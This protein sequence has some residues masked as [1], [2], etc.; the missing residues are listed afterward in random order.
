MEREILGMCIG[1]STPISITYISSTDN[2]PVSGEYVSLD[3]SGK[4]V[5]GMVEGTLRGSPAIPED[6]LNLESVSKIMEFEEESEHY[7]KGSIKLLGE[8]VHGTPV[9]PK[10]PP[11]P[12]T[13]ICR[14]DSKVLKE[15][16]SK[17]EIKIGT[18]LSHPEVE[19]HI[20]ANKMLTRHLAVLAITGAGKSNT[21]SVL[22]EGL[23]KL[24]G[25][26]IIFDMHSEYVNAR[27]S[28]K[29]N[30]VVPMLNPLYLSPTE[31]KILVDIGKD[32]HVQERYLRKAYHQAME[33]V[34]QGGSRDFI[35]VLISILEDIQDEEDQRTQSE[36]NALVGVI[37]KVEDFNLKYKGLV[38]SGAGDILD[39]FIQGQANVIDLGQVD[40][41]YSD[42]IVSHVLRKLLNKRKNREIPPAFCILEEAHILAPA[43]RPTLSKYWIDRISREG[44]KFGVGL[45]MV[46]QRPKSLDANSL[47]Q[48]NNSIIMRLIEPSDQRHVQ[49]S[50]ERLSDDLVSQLSSLNIGEAVLLGLMTKIP[51]LV[52]IDRFPGKISGGDPDIIG[53]WKERVM[54]SK[55]QL[56]KENS[57]IDDLY[58]GM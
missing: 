4:T 9:I 56:K 28:R 25:M 1:E 10:V 38:S 5:L 2:M 46:S 21:V 35:K 53:E 24:E 23:L 57:E 43:G 19:V 20:D 42:V 16:F 51:A 17:G 3:Y 13:R 26:P 45:C 14:A 7:I 50:S 29:V 11:P 22:L 6:I 39:S 30:R 48:A 44:R 27:F 47:S 36:K 32:A 55:D 54:K 40:E 31:F 18:L 12:G 15:V 33:L 37:N 34:R 52:K 49:Q 58:G 8:I 41:D